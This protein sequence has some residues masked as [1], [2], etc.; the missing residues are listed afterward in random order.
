MPSE[1][2]K[3]IEDLL[4][5]SA[6]ARRAQFGSDPKMPNPMRARLHDEIARLTRRDEPE[7]RAPWLRIWWPR[8]SIGAA[9][10]TRVIGAPLIWWRTQ[11]Q[12]GH[13]TLSLATN[14]P[15][16]ARQASR[17]EVQTLPAPAT[18][19]A[20]GVVA[21]SNTETKPVDLAQAAPENSSALRKFAEV[22]L[23]PA[24]P[25]SLAQDKKTEPTNLKQQFSQTL[26]RQAFRA[27]AKVKLAA[28]ILNTFQIEQEGDQIRVVDA[29]GSTYTGKIEPISRDKLKGGRAAERA[30]KPT[31]EAEAVSNQFYFRATGYN[32]S[33]KK[34]LV[35]EANY[36]AAATPQQKAPL[37]AGAKGQQPLPA[38]IF[39][40]AKINGEAPVSVD[41]ISVPAE[42]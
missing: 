8:L 27:N 4:E 33:L 15:A 31:N 2:K 19:S 24:A 6:K 9:A 25:S 36:I 28:N 38:R 23:A 5:A 40:A 37:A 32:G 26:A 3:P 34:S 41:A 1:P 30:A 13:V 29:D 20:A 18:K 42:H 12:S 17:L 39:G 21:E 22:A 14:Q 11:Q 7:R 35:F 10:A 16:V